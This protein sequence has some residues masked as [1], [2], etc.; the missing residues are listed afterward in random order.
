MML[1]GGVLEE[2]DVAAEPCSR[3][4]LLTQVREL[5]ERLEAETAVLQ[6]EIVGRMVTVNCAALPATL[7]ESELFGYEK[8]PSRGRSP[9]RPAASRSRIAARCCSMRSASC[10]SSCRARPA[11]PGGSR[12]WSPRGRNAP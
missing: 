6:Q 5:T 2:T 11:G 9:G 8:A 12:G 10:R 7:I 3:E 4:A 1:S